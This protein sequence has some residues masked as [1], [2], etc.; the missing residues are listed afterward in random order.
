MSID[1]EVPEELGNK[2]T[3]MPTNQPKANAI[4]ATNTGTKTE[5][6]SSEIIQEIMNKDITVQ[7]GP[8]LGISPIVRRTLLD[9]V[10]G[11]HVGGRQ[12]VE[13]NEKSDKQQK[14]VLRAEL[15]PLSGILLKFRSF[16]PICLNLMM[17]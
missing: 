11:Q 5:A 14:K 2:M 7:L 10:K 9:V 3:K 4:K 16:L 13:Q 8:L 17:C 6:V 1:Q 15:W 12:T